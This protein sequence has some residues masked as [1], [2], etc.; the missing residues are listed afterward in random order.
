MPLAVWQ[1]SV[2]ENPQ[3]AEM[4]LVCILA[5]PVTYISEQP[6]PEA[7]VFRREAYSEDKKY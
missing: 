6:H 1:V 3:L 7:L 2:S 5:V 4:L